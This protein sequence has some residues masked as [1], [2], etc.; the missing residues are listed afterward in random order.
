MEIGAFYSIRNIKMRKAG[1]LTYEAKMKEEDK[2]SKLDPEGNAKGHTA[3][4][5]LLQYVF[6]ELVYRMSPH[7]RLIQTKGRVGLETPIYRTFGGANLY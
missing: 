1:N 2:I 4:K 6:F 7:G 3:L 5:N